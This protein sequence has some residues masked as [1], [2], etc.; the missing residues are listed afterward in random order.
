MT[1][2]EKARKVQTSEIGGCDTCT[3]CVKVGGQYY[4]E[5]NGKMLMPMFLY[6]GRC[7]HKPSDYKGAKGM[8]YKRRITQHE[9]PNGQIVLECYDN[10]T[11]MGRKQTLNEALE[12]LYELE[13]KIENGTL[14]ELPTPKWAITVGGSVGKPNYMI[15]YRSPIAEY[16]IGR[17]HIG[18]KDIEWRKI[19]EEFD[20]K[21]QAEKRL[22]ELGE[23]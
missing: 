10:S 8:K 15:E 14:V 22:K 21:E 2:L 9:R 4:C 3:N 19:L 16:Y 7:M 23:K 11:E 6:V 5:A 17:W 13:E 18:F 12:K 20:S 1:P